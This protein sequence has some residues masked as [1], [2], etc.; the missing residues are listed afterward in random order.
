MINVL[1]L[2]KSE[3]GL[4]IVIL[5]PSPLLGS[6]SPQV[7]LA[8]GPGEVE[9]E[10]TVLTVLPTEEV[11]ARMHQW[12]TRRSPSYHPSTI[13]PQLHTQMHARL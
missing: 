12:L 13:L 11:F 1:Y 7:L 6:I 2:K 5:P 10:P 8:S 4:L 9:Y 3:Q